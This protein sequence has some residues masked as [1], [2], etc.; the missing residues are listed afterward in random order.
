MSDLFDHYAGKEGILQ[1]FR[2]IPT[3]TYQ[4][5]TLQP[6]IL[7]GIFNPLGPTISTLS[8]ATDLE[9]FS[10]V[11]H[12]YLL[13]NDLPVGPLESRVYEENGYCS[14]ISQSN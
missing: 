11:F 6:L 4:Q 1:S 3:N 13:H 2:P 8:L 14:S 7:W 12:K 9:S 10:G 5:T